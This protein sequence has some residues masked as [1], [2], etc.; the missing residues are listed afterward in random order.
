MYFAYRVAHMKVVQM[1][2]PTRTTV[3]GFLLDNKNV[4]G[5]DRGAI[6]RYLSYLSNLMPFYRFYIGW[7]A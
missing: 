1:R 3:S 5:P 4:T 2:I 6:P 7:Q